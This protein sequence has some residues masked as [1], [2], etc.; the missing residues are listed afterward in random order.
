MPFPRSY[1][2]VELFC[3]GL[4]FS[5]WNILTVWV[6]FVGNRHVRWNQLT[7][8]LTHTVAIKTEEQCVWELHPK[9]RW[10]YEFLLCRTKHNLQYSHINIHCLELPC[11]VLNRLF[12]TAFRK[13][14]R[15][16]TFTP[17]GFKRGKIDMKK[18]KLDWIKIILCT[19]VNIAVF[20]GLPVIWNGLHVFC[21]ISKK[22]SLE[23]TSLANNLS[24]YHLL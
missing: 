11:M 14:C 12:Q 22:F 3:I 6:N 20:N 16:G 19:K 24:F 10:F 15:N 4:F 13:L 2:R 9:C 17:Y 5:C 23:K 18:N 8:K 21:G 1:L 7:E